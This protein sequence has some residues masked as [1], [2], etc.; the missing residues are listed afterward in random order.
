VVTS[1]MLGSFLGLWIESELADS[2][3]RTGGDMRR[4]AAWK[5][6]ESRE[7]RMEPTLPGRPISQNAEY[8]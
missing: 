8:R 6:V 4:A 1:F 7:T 2:Q 3:S 5:E